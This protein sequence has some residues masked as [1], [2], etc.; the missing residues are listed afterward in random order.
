MDTV[1]LGYA[2]R[3]KDGFISGM[4]FD[5]YF[6]AYDYGTQTFGSEF[7]GVVWFDGAGKARID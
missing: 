5:T 4:R 1:I 6:E 7:E 3:T 2:A